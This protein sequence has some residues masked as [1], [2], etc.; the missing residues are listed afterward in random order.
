[1]RSSVRDRV[2]AAWYPAVA[3]LAERA[4]QRETRAKL[5]AAAAG[6]TLELGAG[7]GLNVEHYPAAVTELVLTDPS[8][9]MLRLLGKRLADTGRCTARLVAAGAERLPFADSS[10]DTVVATFVHCTVPDPDA[11]LREIARVLRPGGRYIFLEH[12][13]SPDSRLLAI[14]Q[15]LL[16]RPH[17]IVGAGCHPNRRFEQTL[18]TSPLQVERLVRGRQ[19]RSSPT[20][21]PIVHGIASRAAQH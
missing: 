19:P 15:D 6:R 8:R 17:V 14:A 7:S 12:V 11:A 1:M 21:R 16:T 3:G 10:F 18:A 13:R 20:V 9:A 4:G 2:F 5:T